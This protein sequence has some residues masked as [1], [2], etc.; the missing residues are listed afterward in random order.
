M[1]TALGAATQQYFEGL[2]PYRVHLRTLAVHPAFQRRG[3]GAALCRCVLGRAREQGRAVTLFASPLGRPLYTSLGF[4]YVGTVDVQV[5]G[6]EEK[7]SLGAMVLPC[8][9]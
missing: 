1:Q 6:E 2:G 3:A 5:E 4:S 7:L 9:S 8:C